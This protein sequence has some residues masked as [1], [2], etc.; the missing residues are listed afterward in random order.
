MLHRVRRSRHHAEQ[1]LSRARGRRD[2]ALRSRRDRNVGPR[3]SVAAHSGV[4]V[5]PDARR[6]LSHRHGG[7][8]RRRG[9]RPAHARQARRSRCARSRWPTISSSPSSIWSTPAKAKDGRSVAH[10]AA[11]PPQ[12]GGKDFADRRSGIQHRQPVCAPRVSIRPTPRPT[13]ARGST[14]PPTSTHDATRPVDHEHDDHDH[15]D[16][17]HH[18]LHDRDIASFCFTREAA[19]RARGAAPAARRL[20]AESRAQSACASKAS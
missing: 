5:R 9:E 6:A 13:R 3:R 14:P 18:H 17:D 20:A 8:D 7:R 12:S 11:A 1:S 2:S 16:H 15:D 19:D 10:R 4:P